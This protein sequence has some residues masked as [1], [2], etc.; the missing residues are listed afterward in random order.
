MRQKRI[1][2]PPPT[3]APLAGSVDRNVIGLD[4]IPAPHVAPLAGS[5]DRNY[6]D[7]ECVEWRDCR[8]PRGERG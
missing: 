7:L 5:V 8:S 6:Y 1:A 2:I 4:V 3:V